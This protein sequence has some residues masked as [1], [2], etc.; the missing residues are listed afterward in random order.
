MD[1]SFLNKNK[2]DTI[3][4]LNSIRD[5]EN[6]FKFYPTTDGLTVAGK[7]MTLGYSCFALKTYK[8][9]GEWENLESN[10]K[11]NWIHYINSYQKNYDYFPNNSFIDIQYL[12]NF[13]KAK[14]KKIHR[15]IAK[16]LIKKKKFETRKT[17]SLRHIRSETK[18]AIATIN[19]VGSVNKKLYTD[20]PN[21]EI[22]IK[23]FLD[24]LDWNFPWQAGA[25]FASLCVFTK[26][27]I[28]ELTKQNRLSN[29]IYEYLD[30]LVDKENGCYF[31][32]RVD[33]SSELING[34]MKVITGLDWI[35]K[36]IHYPEKLIDLA[37]ENQSSSD[38]CDL[39]D[40][41]YV[42]YMALKTTNYRKKE[43]IEYLDDILERVLVHKYKHSGY[44][45]YTSK[46]QIYYYGL[47][48][49]E[50]KNV[51]DLHGTV[52]LNWAIA[53]IAEINELEENNYLTL[54][55]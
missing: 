39:V 54:K 25:Q 23:L 30:H 10:Y 38:G 47:K 40:I 44:S 45:Y 18:Q 19:Q 2:E 4:F 32:G 5:E 7:S 31:K 12:N 9:I 48:I 52:L 22:K 14:N 28:T 46:S 49:S 36:K 13:F 16:T 43:I 26:T 11:L 8:I 17:E 41:V 33:N 51:P 20:F 29:V 1:S 24:S 34:A 55:P 37:L 21:S 35:D 53:M 6:L 3:I 27:Q 50:G 42:L 15:D